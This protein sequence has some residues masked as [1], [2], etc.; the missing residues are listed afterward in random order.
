MKGGGGR[1]GGGRG[2]ATTRDKP[3]PLTER[4]QEKQERGEGES[5]FSSVR[6][7]V[8]PPRWPSGFKASTSRA[9]DPGF[10]SRLRHGDFFRV[11]S[12]H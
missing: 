5:E 12:Y 4:G 3:V 11:E 7:L 6:P 1:E 2:G 9:E 10:E 8:I